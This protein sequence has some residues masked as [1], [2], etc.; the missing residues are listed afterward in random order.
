MSNIL[1][2]GTWNKNCLNELMSIFFAEDDLGNLVTAAGNML[3]SPLIVVDDTFHVV[4]HYQTHDFIDRIF[5]DSIMHREISYEIG[6]IISQS[7]TLTA[8]NPDYVKLDESPYRRRFAPL[9]SSGVRLG[10]LI[11]VDIN[12][13]LKEVPNETWQVVEEILAKQMFIEECRQDKPF[14]TAEAV[15]MHLLDGGFTSAAYFRLQAASTYLADFHPTGFA[16]IN[17]ATYHKEYLSSQHLKEELLSRFPHSH[18]LLYR[19]DVFLFLHRKAEPSEFAVVAEEFGLK[20]V[21][22]DGLADLFELPGL[23]RTACEALELV[24]G[25]RF[26]GKNVFTVE[27]L[28][29]LLLLKNLKGRKDLVAKEIREL[30]AHDKTKGTSYCETLYYYLICCRSLQKTCDML[31]THRNTVLYRIRRMKDDFGIPLDDPLAHADLLFG[32]ALLLFEE[33]GADFFLQGASCII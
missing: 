18:P 11:C 10:H 17:L 27:Q 15:L 6:A 29:T 1:S 23:Y 32:V 33:R 20:V 26:R 24:S 16:L 19:G 28:R 31:F 3:E 8:G 9:M 12:G 14:E 21:L 30:A 7:E 25:E 13:H 2:N 22:T 4:A 5:Q